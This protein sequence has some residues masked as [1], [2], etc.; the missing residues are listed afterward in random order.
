MNVDPQVWMTDRRS[1]TTSG[2]DRRWLD[3]ATRRYCFASPTSMRWPSG[4]RM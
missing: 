2:S 3:L 1:Q 4:S